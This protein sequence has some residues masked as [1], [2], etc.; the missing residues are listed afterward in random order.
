MIDLEKVRK[1]TPG[2][3]KLI[4]FNNAGA[5]LVPF[6]VVKS[7][8]N[9]LNEEQYQGGYEAAD[10]YADELNSFYTYAASLLNCNARNIAF[11]TNA[12][13]SYNRALSGYSGRL[14]QAI[15]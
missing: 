12:T 3:E 10:R 8:Q 9:Y 14:D 6:P 11:T 1:D 15:R 4:H 13:E 5:A 7:I 2:C